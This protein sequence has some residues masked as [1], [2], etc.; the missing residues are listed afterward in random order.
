[1]RLLSSL[2]SVNITRI[3]PAGTQVRPLE[4]CWLMKTL[5]VSLRCSHIDIWCLCIDTISV[6]KNILISY[7]Y[8]IL[9]NIWYEYFKLCTNKIRIKY[10]TFIQVY[11]HIAY[12][13]I[14]LFIYFFFEEVS[15]DYP[16]ELEKTIK[17]QKHTHSH[18]NHS[19]LCLAAVLYLRTGICG[20]G[21]LTSLNLIMCDY[22]YEYFCAIVISFL[23]HLIL[24]F[25]PYL[26]FF[27]SAFFFFPL[28]GGSRELTMHFTLNWEYVA[29]VVA[30]DLA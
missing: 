24:V 21:G 9:I 23:S 2:W 1:M 27:F 22:W 29:M 18:T 5:A 13:G 3:E 11:S 30:R 10:P 17:N 20:G 7:C 12:M 16:D 15:D 25:Q 4:L 14:Y 19:T 28:A 8:D 6:H 26:C